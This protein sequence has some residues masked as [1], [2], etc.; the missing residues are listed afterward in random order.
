MTAFRVLVT[1]SRTW[2]DRAAIETAL[3]DQT[4]PDGTT[5]T[6]VHGACPSGA[7]AIAARLA[8]GMGWT[9]EAHPANWRE[10]GTAAGFRRNAEMVAAGADLCLAFIRDASPGATHCA[11]LAARAGI[12]VQ[13]WT[14]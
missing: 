5:P 7:D 13:R 9:V 12:P 14:A 11:R 3:L 8:A 10:H 4:R 1:G 6:L 2:T